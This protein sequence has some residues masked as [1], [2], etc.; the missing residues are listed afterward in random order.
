MMT[1]KDEKVRIVM[2]QLTEDERIYW[3]IEKDPGETFMNWRDEH[4]M[5]GTTSLAARTRKTYQALNIRL[6]LE[7]EK[8]VVRTDTSKYKTKI[9][10]DIDRFL[11]QKVIRPRKLD[12][13]LGHEVHGASFATL[14]GNEVSNTILMNVRARRIDAF[15]RYIVAA[16]ADCL[17]TPVNI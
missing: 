3:R 14:R 4:G 17:P 2:Q 1:S 6:K 11:T 15:F 8:M 13:L 16:R 12:S 9:A 5:R 7:A 10:D